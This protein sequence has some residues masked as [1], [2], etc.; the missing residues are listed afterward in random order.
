MIYKKW[1][2]NYPK[3]A[4]Y[5]IVTTEPQRTEI[6]HFDRIYRIHRMRGSRASEST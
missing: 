5:Y 3:V 1:E 2:K 6:G 4:K